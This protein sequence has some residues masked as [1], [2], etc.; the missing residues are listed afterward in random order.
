MEHTHSKSKKG[1]I[2]LSI[3]DH[4]KK[5]LLQILDVLEIQ[6][7]EIEGL[8]ERVKTLEEQKNV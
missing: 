5:T 8:R 3:L 7:R 1:D 4:W 6:A 2:V